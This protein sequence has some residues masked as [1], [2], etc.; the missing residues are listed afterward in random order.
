MTNRGSADLTIANVVIGG[1]DSA[2]FRILN[3]GCSG[4]TLAPQETCVV[5][6]RFEPSSGGTKNAVLRFTHDAAAAPAEVALAGTARI[7]V[8]ALS[9]GAAGVLVAA[10]CVALLR[11]A[12]RRR[13]RA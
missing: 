1:A 5:E 9:L 4:R 13:G 6:V 11:R 8:P 2:H 3:D 12:G 7:A 10:F